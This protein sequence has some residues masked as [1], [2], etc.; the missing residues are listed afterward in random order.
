M[1]G[2]AEP[3]ITS[4]NTQRTPIRMARVGAVPS[5][6]SHLGPVLAVLVLLV[7][8]GLVVLLGL[9]VLVLA[10]LVLAVP[11]SPVATEAVR[12]RDPVGWVFDPGGLSPVVGV[13]G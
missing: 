5:R 10:V 6:G 1:I 7:L 3:T 13:D 2:E 12:T 11:A 9:A 4:P 8:V